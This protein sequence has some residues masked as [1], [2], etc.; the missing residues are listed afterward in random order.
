[1]SYIMDLSPKIHAILFLPFL[2]IVFQHNYK[3]Y[4][5]SSMILSWKKAEDHCMAMGGHLTSIKNG[6]E[7]KFLVSLVRE[8]SEY[9]VGGKGKDGKYKWSDGED[10][11]YTHWSRQ[12]GTHECVSISYFTGGRWVTKNCAKYKYAI[13]KLSCKYFL[14]FSVLKFVACFSSCFL[15]CKLLFFNFFTLVDRTL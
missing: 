11:T 6:D 14:I 9:W 7:N 15:F 13:C 5:I 3:R 4:H 1:M 10:L 8:N 12:S 2:Y